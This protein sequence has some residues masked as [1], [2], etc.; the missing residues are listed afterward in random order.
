MPL[1]DEN[2]LSDAQLLERFLAVRD[3]AAFAALVRRHGPMVLGVCRRVLHHHHDAE[4]AFQATFL[5]LAKKAAAVRRESLGGWLYTVAYRAALEARA[6]AAR[7]SARERQVEDMPHPEVPP[8]E[9]HDWRPLLDRE[10]HGLPPKYRSAVVLCNLEGKTRK[11]AALELGVAEGTLSSRLATARALLA[12]RLAR[13]GVALSGG[14][15]AVELAHGATAAVPAPLL[16]STVQAATM[17]AA[18][19]AA[20]LATPAAGVMK[21]VLKAMLLT[22]LKLV[23][24]TAMLTAL[25]GVGGIAFRASSQARAED[26]STNEL[27]ALRKENTLLRLNVQVLLEKI[28]AQEA[29][30][31][32]LRGQAGG[33]G[34]AATAL[35]AT[36]KATAPPA[37][38]N[39]MRSQNNIKQMALAF[40]N[41]ADTNTGIFPPAAICDARGKPLL[42]WRVAILPYLEQDALYKEFHLDEP[43]DSDHNKKLLDKMPDIYALPGMRFKGDAGLT[44]Y[45][46]FVGKNAIF[47]GGRKVPFPASITDGTSNTLL[48]VEAAKPVP[49]TKPAD[50]PLGEEDPRT[51][52]GG[53]HGDFVNVGL[54]DGSVRRINR[55][56]MSQE[57]FR[58]AIMPNDGNP[59]GSDW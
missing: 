54:C 17:I 16:S 19:Q 30:L 49:W 29:E 48:V 47:D 33:S 27:E 41:Y 40:H 20:A 36:P 9:V 6:A 44:I 50:I 38:A 3:E 11:E 51:Q 18:G 45:Q 14:I 52:V 28:H 13:G 24:V 32:A 56:K 8:A 1:T 55:K 58:N 7:R 37:D 4:D 43:W 21:G 46:V 42:S 5:V 53:W 31:L 23:V 39:V 22:K 34:A 10:L 12:R 26:Q 59:L 2:S 35:G 25:V 57:T 15:L